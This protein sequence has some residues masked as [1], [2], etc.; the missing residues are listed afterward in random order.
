MDICYLST[1]DKASVSSCVRRSIQQKFLT[2]TMGKVREA[3]HRH[4]LNVG[5]AMNRAPYHVLEKTPGQKVRYVT[6]RHLFSHKQSK[7]T[8]QSRPQCSIDIV[9]FEYVLLLQYSLWCV[10]HNS[11]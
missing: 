1:D 9:V 6:M 2:T 7:R 3:D 5:E 4:L 8:L 10:R 11:D